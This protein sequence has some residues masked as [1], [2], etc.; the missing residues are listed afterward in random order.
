MAIRVAD[1]TCERR[2]Q[3]WRKEAPEKSIRVM[4]AQIWEGRRRGEE[5]LREWDWE[6]RARQRGRT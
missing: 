5:G 6:E 1:W 4:L 2:N 3:S